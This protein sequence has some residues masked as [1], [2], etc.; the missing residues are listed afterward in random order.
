MSANKLRKSLATGRLPE[1]KSAAH[2]SG[3][4]Q[5]AILKGGRAMRKSLFLAAVALLFGSTAFAQEDK[6]YKDDTISVKAYRL[7]LENKPKVA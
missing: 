5:D 1:S 2:A 4:N 6:G 3:H 7:K